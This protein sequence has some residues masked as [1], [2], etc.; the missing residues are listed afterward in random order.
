[1]SLEPILIVGD[2]PMKTNLLRLLLDNEGYGVRTA[3]DAPE[4]LRVLESFRPRLILMDLEFP[5]MEGMELAVQLKND[6]RNRDVLIL[7]VTSLFQKV[8]ENRVKEPGS[9]GYLRGP[10]DTQNLP[11]LLANFLKKT[12]SPGTFRE[13]VWNSGASK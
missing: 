7:V 11:A 13:L 8:E 3:L 9:D 5:G 10:L 1:M 4:A 6:P 2:D 12:S